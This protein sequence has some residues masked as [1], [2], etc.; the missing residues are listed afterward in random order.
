MLSIPS[1]GDDAGALNPDLVIPVLVAG[2]VATGAA[3]VVTNGLD[4][5]AN[6][7]DAENVTAEGNAADGLAGSSPSGAVEDALNETTN[8]TNATANTSLG[9]GTPQNGTATNRTNAT[10]PPTNGSTSNATEAGPANVSLL[11]E[12]WRTV[13]ATTLRMYETTDAVL[14]PDGERFYLVGDGHA[15]HDTEGYANQTSVAVVTALDADD[16]DLVWRTLTAG[17]GDEGASFRAVDVAPDGTVFAAGQNRL[18]GGSEV[19]LQAVNGSSGGLGISVT[20]R[21]DGG[22]AMAKDVVVAPD[23][24]HVAVTG[25]GD[26]GHLTAVYDREDSLDRFAWASVIGR[27]SGHSRSIGEA[28]AVSP[29]GEALYVTGKYEDANEESPHLG[30]Q[31]YSLP[32]GDSLW[33]SKYDSPTGDWD[34]GYDVAVGP[35]SERVVVTGESYG[36]GTH[37][38]YATVVYDAASGR[39]VWSARYDGPDHGRDVPTSVAFS[40]DGT[41]VYVTGRAQT[42]ERQTDVTTLAYEA[43]NGSQLWER[44]YDGGAHDGDRGLDLVPGLAGQVVYVT[45]LSYG[46]PGG[47]DPDVATVGYESLTGTTLAEARLDASE[48][49]TTIDR[50]AALALTPDGQRLL[51]AGTSLAA[52]GDHRP[53]SA[54]YEVPDRGADGDDG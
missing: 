24:R 54:A 26:G 2:M 30:T 35:D 50:P 28:I 19:F 25:G 53:L 51:V 20:M 32:D 43:A 21:P 13:D 40:P 10:A 46:E 27:T 42:S 5:P 39:E 49:N 36:E 3:V 9:N 1:L 45:A 23:G 14:G 31:A 18:G 48:T 15:T 16:G 12:R 34:R 7:T 41:T 11:E 6:G 29:S 22:T 38:D 47:T 8:A 33:L 4:D 52:H 37:G 17:T 44:T